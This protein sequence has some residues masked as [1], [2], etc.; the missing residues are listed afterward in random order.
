MGESFKTEWDMLQ[1]EVAEW[2]AG[3]FGDS[4]LHAKMEH[5]RRETY[6][7]EQTP[8]EPFEWAD[9]MLIFLHSMKKQ[10]LTMDDLLSAC[11][12]KFHI[13]Q[14]REWCQPDKH[15]VVEHKRPAHD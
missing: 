11:W 7:F 9:V 4:D 15:G 8:D 5:I 12:E 3:V 10:G 13:V 14:R 2:A 6:E 1:Q